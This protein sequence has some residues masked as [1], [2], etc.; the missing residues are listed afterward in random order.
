MRCQRCKKGLRC[1]TVPLL[2]HD[3]IQAPGGDPQR[4]ALF[5]HGILGTKANW[6]GIARQFV[7]ARPEWA[8]VT[9]DLP[10]HGESQ[11]FQAPYTLSGC[12]EA[13]AELLD[14]LEL[15]TQLA[16][17]HSFGGKVVLDLAKRL[18]HSSDAARQ[19]R[20]LW[21]IDSPPGAREETAATDSHQVITKLRTLPERFSSRQDFGAQMK[22]RKLS[23][24]ITI[25][26]AMNLRRSDQGFVF[27]LDLDAIEALLGSY[28]KTE[29]WSDLE[30]MSDE[31]EVHCILG[32]CSTVF[33]AEERQR[34]ESW[35][36]AGLIEL[37]VIEGAGHWVH[38]ERPDAVVAALLAAVD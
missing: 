34:L 2:A 8:A 32:G 9:V 11:G 7:K 37:Q 28:F 12:G 35:A 27:P 30:A 3:R 16:L 15:P 6:R 10:M 14:G 38:A 19:L 18:A 21:I 31:L 33:L 36:G 17:G 22:A 26:L 13:L 1:P 4:I 25:W 20:Q 29:A 5:V 23:E 24:A